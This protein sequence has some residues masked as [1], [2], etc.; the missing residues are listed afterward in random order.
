MITLELIGRDEVSQR[1]LFLIDAAGAEDIPTGLVLNDRFVCLLA[2]DASGVSDDT[3][4]TLARRLFAAGCVYICC[5]GADCSRVHDLFDL[6]DLERAPNGPWVMSTWHENEP[7]A[8]AIWF[9]LFNAYPDDA[10]FDGCR[11]TLGLSLGSSTWAA[12]IRQAFSD[13]RK[14]NKDVVE[15]EAG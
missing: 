12:E 9:S 4:K 11:S 8:E 2:W 7:L 14:F 13:P 3:V 6:V 5:W 10:F 1:E 15:S